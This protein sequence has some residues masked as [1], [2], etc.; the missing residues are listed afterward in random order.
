MKFNSLVIESQ[1]IGEYNFNNI[2]AAIAIGAYFDVD[3]ADIKAAIEAYT[4]ENNRSQIIKRGTNTIVLDA[5][6]ANPTSMKVA[7]DSFSKLAGDQKLVVLGDMFELGSS[8]AK[9]HQDIAEYAHS[10]GFDKLSLVGENF[11]KI[12]LPSEKTECYRNF[13]ELKNSW[14]QA[15]LQNCSLLIKGSRGMTLE[16][17]L[18]LL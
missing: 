14:P 5:Y 6:N 11:Y 2:S 3:N 10:L 15:P 8:A 17:V 18:E 16:R 7:L 12:A 1:L 13:E 9:E 4:P